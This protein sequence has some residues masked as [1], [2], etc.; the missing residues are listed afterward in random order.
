M[1]PTKAKAKTTKTTAP[2][3][4]RTE[5]VDENGMAC[6]EIRSNRIIYRDDFDRLGPLTPYGESLLE[7]EIAHAAKPDPVV[8]FK[9]LATGD[10]LPLPAYMSSGAS[11]IDLYAASTVL[12]APTWR[13]L[14]PT[15]W[16]VEIPPGYEGQIRPR[17]GLVLE[18]GVTV[19]NA[20]GTIDCDYRGEVKIILANLGEF[21]VIIRRGDRIA[22]L[23][24]APVSRA[25]IIEAEILSKTIRDQMGFGSSGLR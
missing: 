11:G 12:L 15:G 3:F 10:G 25:T 2:D 20:P 4:E 7:T 9:R 6:T 16:A 24:I 13:K 8:K 21:E 5:F 17:S 18:H 1:K 14:V 22:Q 19:L 23:V